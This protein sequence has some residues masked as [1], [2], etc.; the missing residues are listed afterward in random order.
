MFVYTV[1]L[2]HRLR[3]MGNNEHI[4][5]EI[6]DW[7]K[8]G[9]LTGRRDESIDDML[10]VE[11]AMRLRMQTLRERQKRK[12][13]RLEFDICAEKDPIDSCIKSQLR[14]A[15]TNQPVRLIS[16]SNFYAFTLDHIL[17]VKDDHEYTWTIENLQI[18]SK[19]FN[20][21]EGSYSHCG[22]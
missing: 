11:R 3:Q 8:T 5:T 22:I 10:T 19:L 20:Q 12:T 6:T 17:P 9:P 18:M 16:T 21:I 13:P 15:I 7:V 1:R 14:C 4:F 2:S